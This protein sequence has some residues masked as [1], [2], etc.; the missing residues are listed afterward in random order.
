MQSYTGKEKYK[1]F[2]SYLYYYYCCG[3]I[4]F[5]FIITG[6]LS[7][8]RA[9]TFAI[10]SAEMPIATRLLSSSNSNGESTAYNDSP[11]EVMIL[12]RFKRNVGDVSYNLP[13]SVS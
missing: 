11:S 6:L 1:K 7:S 12:S 5:H 3:I 9:L 13:L 2:F 8:E 10:I 4:K